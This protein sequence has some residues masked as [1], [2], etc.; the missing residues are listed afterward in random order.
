LTLLKLLRAFLADTKAVSS[1][2]YAIIA[3][4][5]AG[6]IIVGVNITGVSFLN[7]WT[8]VAAALQ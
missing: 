7:I 4:G 6:T 2:Q 5:I 8:E 3:V 1:I